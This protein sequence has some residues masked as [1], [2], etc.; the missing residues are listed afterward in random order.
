MRAEKKPVG[1]TGLAAGVGVR[2]GEGLRAGRQ[3]GEPWL[4]A[5]PGEGFVDALLQ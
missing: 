4:G 2:G 5:E 1:E 3:V